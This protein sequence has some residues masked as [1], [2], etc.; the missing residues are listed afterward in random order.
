[1]EAAVRGAEV[2]LS[3]IVDAASGGVRINFAREG[4]IEIER[5]AAG[6]GSFA[7]KV[8]EATVQAVLSGFEDLL[9][10]VAPDLCVPV[11][12]IAGKLAGLFFKK[13]LI[14]AEINPLFVSK[15]GSVAG[16]AKVVLD[17]NVIENDAELARLVMARGDVYRD[18]NR[19][20]AEGFDFIDLDDTGAI[21]LITTGAG[22][23]MMLID[24][25]VA[26]GVR[27]ANF[28]DI[29]TGQMRGDPARLV[30]VLHWLAAKSALKAVFVNVFAGITDLAE[31]ARLLV[32]ALHS[33]PAL[34]APVIV[35]I[36]GR[37]E[38][39]ARSYL[40]ARRPDLAVYGDME[41][42]MNHV[43]RIAGA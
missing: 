15:S 30:R 3:M 32:E 7:T 35:R 17:S 34:T 33:C 5:T 25:L 6:G 8:C 2:Y 26:K 31:F 9:A 43:T 13:G 41:A 4:G 22:L 11:L 20:I 21:G 24:E 40:A 19:K 16:D 10:A 29:R 12:P 38:E 18:V 28:C 37:N 36:A 27:V 42:A 39:S 23:S 1:V 14:L